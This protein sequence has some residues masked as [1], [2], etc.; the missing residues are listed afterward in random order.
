MNV[1]TTDLNEHLWG[2]S[3][4]CIRLTNHE[5]LEGDEG[6]VRCTVLNKL[7]LWCIVGS[8]CLTI[9]AFLGL[10]FGVFERVNDTIGQHSAGRRLTLPSDSDGTLASISHLKHLSYDL[11]KAT[12]MV[13]RTQ[14][15]ID[16]VRFFDAGHTNLGRNERFAF[17]T[18]SHVGTDAW[19]ES[20]PHLKLDF[21]KNNLGVVGDAEGKVSIRLIEVSI[22]GEGNHGRT[23]SPC[24]TDLNIERCRELSRV[25]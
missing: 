21:V 16:G 10:R 22:V 5:S 12:V 23:R 1:R 18:N 24:L 14:N 25:G 8:A 13:L 4:L 17:K 9:H 3:H 20:P 11:N 2:R 19:T 15:V 6:R 7:S